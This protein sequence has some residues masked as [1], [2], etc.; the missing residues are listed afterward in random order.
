MHSVSTKV[1][2]VGDSEFCIF[3]FLKLHEFYLCSPLLITFSKAIHVNII[4]SENVTLLALKMVFPDY[5]DDN[6]MTMTMEK[7]LES[8][9][10]SCL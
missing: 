4:K 9:S 6:R 1:K 8:M 5:K 7:L 3:D 10:S 2:E